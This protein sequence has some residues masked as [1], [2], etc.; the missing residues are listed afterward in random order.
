MY[1]IIFLAILALL[2][3]LESTSGQDSSSQELNPYEQQK[4][5]NLLKSFIDPS[6][7]NKDNEDKWNGR[8][9]PENKNE[10]ESA[11]S[12]QNLKDEFPF[13]ETDTVYNSVDNIIEMGLPSEKCD[14]AKTNLTVDW[15]YSP[16]NHTCYSKRIIPDINTKAKIYCEKIPYSYM[17]IHR[18]MT[19]KIEYDDIIPIFGTHR[20]LWPVYGEY[21][22]LPKQRWLHSLEHGGVV[23]LYHPC[24]NQMQIKLLKSLVQNCLRRHVITPYNLLDEDRPFALVT[25]G[26]RLTMS[27]V[28]PGLVKRFIKDRALKGPEEIFTDGNFKD[29]LISRAALVSDWQDSQICPDI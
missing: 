11:S 9:F 3:S 18:C 6:R 8:W 17:A 13:G 5:Y 22:F 4:V 28:D 12:V 15:D 19:D 14:D 20:P 21:K 23:M 1:R 7:P 29:S 27:Y 26:C 10:P 2:V 24:A 16:V 25:W